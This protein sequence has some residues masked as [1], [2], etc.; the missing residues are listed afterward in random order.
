MY[1]PGHPKGPQKRLLGRSP[2]GIQKQL[3]ALTA[4]TVTTKTV[5]EKDCKTVPSE[6]STILSIFILI[7]R[8]VSVSTLILGG[9]DLI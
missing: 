8:Y 1:W 6:T 3:P 4:Q 7:L 5:F 2:T 9:H